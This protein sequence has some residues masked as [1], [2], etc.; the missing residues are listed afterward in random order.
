MPD[1]DDTRKRT[2]VNVFLEDEGKFMMEYVHVGEELMNHTNLINISTI[3][4]NMD[5][6]CGIL[7]RSLVK[8]N[9]HIMIRKSGFYGTLDKRYGSLCRTS[10]N[11][12]K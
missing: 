1:N 11:I 2:E 8:G 9:F 4:I 10:S 12:K 3:E 6:R 5:P 7:T